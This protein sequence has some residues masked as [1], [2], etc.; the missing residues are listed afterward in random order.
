[1]RSIALT[2]FSNWLSEPEPIIGQLL[3][4]NL[5]EPLPE[6]VDLIVAN[7]PYI[8]TDRIPTLQPE[9]QW[10]PVRALDGGAD[11]LD[12]IRT[13]LLQ[14]P[15]KLKPH[16]IILLELDPEQVPP[17]REL[18]Q[19]LFPEAELSV[20]KDLAGVPGI[21]ILSNSWASVIIF[22]K[23]GSITTSLITENL[24]KTLDSTTDS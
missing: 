18:A 24:S 7:L 23:V 11:G 6:P 17:V 12:H 5:L 9:I 3:S 21:V 10:E 22:V 16:G 19:E 14:A 13:L 4:G 20:E 2:L 8:P 15:E 1:M